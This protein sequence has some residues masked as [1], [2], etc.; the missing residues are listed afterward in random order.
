MYWISKLLS[1]R[2]RTGIVLTGACLPCA[3]ETAISP[4]PVQAIGLDDKDK[5][6]YT[7]V[8]QC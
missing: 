6:G 5:G 7:L 3:I 2:V 1:C 4:R 8:I